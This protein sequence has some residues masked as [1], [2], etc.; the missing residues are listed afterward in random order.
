MRLLLILPY[1]IPGYI[2][3]GRKERKGRRYCRQIYIPGIYYTYE[4]SSS[5]WTGNRKDEKKPIA[6]RQT[7]SAFVPPERKR[8]Q[9]FTYSYAFQLHTNTSAVSSTDGMV[10]ILNFLCIFN[11]RWVILLSLSLSLS[12]SLPGRCYTAM[13]RTAPVRVAASVSYKLRVVVVLG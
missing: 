13:V 3:G 10:K 2:W 4:Y 11:A 6:Q 1:R 9:D 8:K 5:G 7:V 12:L